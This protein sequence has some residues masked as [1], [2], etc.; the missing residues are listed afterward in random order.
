MKKIFAAVI[1]LLLIAVL[2]P[3]Y[4]E[5][6]NNPDGLAFTI[7]S[8]VPAARGEIVTV[9]VNV[10]NNPGFTSVGLIVTYNQNVLELVDVMAP[11]VAMPINAQFALMPEQ[12]T[13]W[14]HFINTDMVDWRGNGTIVNMTFHVL[15]TAPTG[16]SAVNL[17]FMD[18]PDG[19]PRNAEGNIL[20]GTRTV[21]G[22]V[23]VVAGTSGAIQIGTSDGEDTSGTG[24]GSVS[25]FDSNISG[26]QPLNDIDTGGFIGEPYTPELDATG[27]G[28]V[29]GP[30]RNQ[31][32]GRIPQTGF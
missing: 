4:A 25:N 16:I 15:S 26:H 21:S 1:T 12:G 6:V 14:I 22:S 17:T 24:A 28:T 32:F 19:T 5:S 13:Q 18:L 30:E 3:I 8:N 7:R 29:H 23:D 20:S 31:G 9:P 27:V 10:S 2:V 11:V